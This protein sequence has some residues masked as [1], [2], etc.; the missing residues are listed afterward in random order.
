MRKFNKFHLHLASDA[1]FSR[2]VDRDYDY[3]VVSEKPNRVRQ[4]VVGGIGLIAVAAATFFIAPAHA[5]GSMA[6]E[7]RTVVVNPT[8]SII[9]LGEGRTTARARERAAAEAQR[10]SNRMELEAFRAQNRRQLEADRAYYKRLEAQRKP[11]K[12]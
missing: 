2:L 4:L 3:V 12:K 6:P 9:R 7:V 11:R 10:H 5:Q 1:D 8:P